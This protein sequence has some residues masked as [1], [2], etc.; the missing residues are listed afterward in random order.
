MPCA[1]N[2]SIFSFKSFISCCFLVNPASFLGVLHAC[3]IHFQDIKP[4]HTLFKEHFFAGF[5]IS[6]LS[7]FSCCFLVNPASFLGVLRACKIHFQDLKP[8][9]TLFKEHFAELFYFCS[10]IILTNSDTRLLL[11]PICRTISFCFNPSSNSFL[12]AFKLSLYCCS[13]FVNPAS[14]LGV[15]RACKI[16]FQD[17]KP[18]HT[19]F[20][21][22][23]AELFYFCSLIILTNSD[24]RLLLIPI[25]RTISFC[26]NPSSNSFLT[27]FKLSLYCCSRFV[28]PASFLG[29]LR[30]LF[31][32]YFSR[33]AIIVFRLFCSCSVISKYLIIVSFL[34]M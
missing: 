3:K 22:H 28:N 30:A 34:K 2:S 26:F 9:H 6:N 10:L 33:F 8:P 14:F 25:C 17:L 18:P 15:L 5:S 7:A 19:L 23:F 32:S 4:P 27:A 11:I 1:F 31:L 12:T 24:T 20:K 21:E 29:V 13:R 16:H